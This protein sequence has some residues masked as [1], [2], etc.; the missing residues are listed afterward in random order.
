MEVGTQRLYRPWLGGLH[1]RDDFLAA[2]AR[3]QHG[4]GQLHA[5]LPL[6]SG[7]LHAGPL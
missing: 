1:A 4:H 7:R 5:A 2:Q 3:L 6:V